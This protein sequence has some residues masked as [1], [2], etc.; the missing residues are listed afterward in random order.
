MCAGATGGGDRTDRRGE[1][2]HSPVNTVMNSCLKKK[3]SLFLASGADA[4]YYCVL[5]ERVLKI[6]QLYI[7]MFV[8]FVV[9]F[10]Y[11][12]FFIETFFAPG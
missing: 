11:Q 4:H 12:K 10:F 5:C 9:T 6:G 3:N 1:P 8:F 2:K 7:L